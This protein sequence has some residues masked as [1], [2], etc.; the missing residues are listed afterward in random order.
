MRL[1][2]AEYRFGQIEQGGRE[3][4]EDPEEH[5]VPPSVANFHVRHPDD[6]IAWID[7]RIVVQHVGEHFNGHRIPF[8]RRTVNQLRRGNGPRADKPAHRYGGTNHVVARNQIDDGTGIA[9]DG[10]EQTLHIARHQSQ[11]AAVGTAHP[12]GHRVLVGAVNCVYT[13]K[14]KLFSAF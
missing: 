11:V 3:V 12:S 1:A 14:I 2:N 4:M 13:R 10:A 6:R 7:V 5:S 9:R 8:A